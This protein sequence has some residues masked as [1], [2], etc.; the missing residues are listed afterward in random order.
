MSRI[1]EIGI[2]IGSFLI[3]SVALAGNYQTCIQVEVDT[4]DS[5]Y[6]IP[7]GPDMGLSEDHWTSCDSGCNV[8]ARG[9][10][11][12]VTNPAWS[13]LNGPWS[14]TYDTDPLTGCYDWAHAATSGFVITVYGYATNSEDT[15][16]RIHDGAYNDVT[17][18][19]GATYSTVLDDITP[20]HN[21]SNTYYI[22]DY[23]PRWTTFA[24]VAFGI[25]RYPY[26]NAD[27]ELH[28]AF[29]QRSNCSSS[30]LAGTASITSGRHYFFVADPD[31]DCSNTASSR[32]FVATHELGH[33]LLRLNTNLNG[34]EP[35]FSV[36]HNEG[37]TANPDSCGT[38]GSGSYTMSS[39]EWNS[40]GFKEG[41]AH[42]IAARIWNDRSQS[43][44]F[45]WT[46][47]TQDLERYGGGGGTGSGGRLENE[48]CT[49]G[50]STSWE[51]AGTNE[52]WLRFFWDFYN[53]ESVACPY[54]PDSIDMLNLYKEVRTNGGL[55]FNT[56]FAGLAI[57]AVTVD[58]PGAPADYC[59]S[60]DRF[61]YYAGLNGIDN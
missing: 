21:G 48:C 34:G 9:V 41:F 6:D 35:N 46:N 26:L 33:A 36:T 38:G 1:V 10:R 4:V 61:D 43:G 16:V 49:S 15:F 12:K 27:K 3:P 29:D 17:T 24:S 18:Y 59:L 57:A 51:D 19:P 52:D 30:S 53:N 56:Y 37:G 39:K 25:M 22:G 28:V 13:V 14:A 32:K 31:A 20:T 8:I 23:V 45:T 40:L 2:A 5:G 58:L 42:F 11:F 47:G 55:A 60:T 54:Y 7:S 50:C 44:A